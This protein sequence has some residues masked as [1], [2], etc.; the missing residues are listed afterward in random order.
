MHLTP[1]TAARGFM[2]ETFIVI[3][4]ILHG[5]RIWSVSHGREIVFSTVVASPANSSVFSTVVASRELFRVQHGG[6]FTSELFRVQHVGRFTSELFRHPYITLYYMI[7]SIIFILLYYIILC[8][9]VLY[10]NLF[11]YIKLY[12]FKLNHIYYSILYYK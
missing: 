11:C 12:H 10:C 8:Y 4:L 2:V 7:C 1:L 5:R 6:R 3:A 9:I